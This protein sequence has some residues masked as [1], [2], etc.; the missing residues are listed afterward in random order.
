MQS[1]L[2]T[3]VSSNVNLKSRFECM[4]SNDFDSSMNNENLF[5]YF[6]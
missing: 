2:N 3:I 4:I 5:S 1:S 6:G